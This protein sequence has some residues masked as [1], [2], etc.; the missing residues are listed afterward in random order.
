MQGS[1][2]MIKCPLCGFEC[3][4]DQC[5]GA[6]N[7]C[8]LHSKRC[9]MIRCPNCGYMIPKEPRLVKIIRDIW[10]RK[11]NSAKSLKKY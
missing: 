3:E 5:S 11:W 9:N 4:E 6:C 1:V 8:P 7:D 2:L 10:R